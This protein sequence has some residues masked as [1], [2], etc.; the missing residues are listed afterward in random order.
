M[1]AERLPFQPLQAARVQVAGVDQP[2]DERRCLLRVPAPVAAPGGVRPPGAERDAERQHRKADEHGLVRDLFQLARRK[3][4]AR[5]GACRPA[6]SSST[7]APNDTESALYDSIIM[8]TW[9]ARM[10]FACSAG[11]SGSMCSGKKT[12]EM[13]KSA[14]MPGTAPRRAPAVRRRARRSRRTAPSP[15]RA[16]SCTRTCS[17]TADGRLR[18]IGTRATVSARRTS[19]SCAGRERRQER[20]R[21]ALAKRWSCSCRRS[22]RRSDSYAWPQRKR[23]ICGGRG[24]REHVAPR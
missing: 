18:P 12:S 23:D 8:P 11:I 6:R 16:R 17:R 1:P 15:S 19:A 7:A 24:E 21:F 4:G 10:R 3:A 5:S 22:S 9:I 20:R 14:A 2:R 13:V